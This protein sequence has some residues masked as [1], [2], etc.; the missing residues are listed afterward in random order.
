MARQNIIKVRKIAFTKLHKI[1]VQTLFNDVIEDIKCFDTDLMHLKETCE[2]LINLQPKTALLYLRDKELGPHKLTPRFDELREQR[3]KFAGIITNQMIN[4]EK[5]NLEG[6]EELVDLTKPIVKKYL[7]CLRRRTKVDSI[8]YLV[9]FFDKLEN[10]PEILDAFYELGFKPYLDKL[11][12]AH[13]EFLKTNGERGLQNARSPKGS[14]LPLQR[15]LQYFLGVFFNQVDYSQHVYKDVDYSGLITRL[16]HT[17]AL[18]TKLIKTRETHSKNKKLKANEAEQTKLKQE[19]EAANN[20]K[21][22]SATSP[23]P[24]LNVKPNGKASITQTKKKGTNDTI[25]GLMNIV[26]K[27]DERK[28]DGDVGGEKQN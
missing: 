17:I 28:R 9:Q 26:K 3:F 23:N 13:E 7:R 18:Y 24:D 20:D 16:N 4:V 19:L 15:E 2:L 21:E 14:T 12:K 6:T 5:A 10:E 22:L 1:E 25:D 27:P 11:W 8:Q